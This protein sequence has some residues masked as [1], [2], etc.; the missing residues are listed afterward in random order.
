MQGQIL[1]HYRI[2]EK[3]GEGGM[4]EVFAAEDTTLGRRVA[5]KV[6]PAAMAA[7]EDRLRRFQREA[8]A[9]AA[10]NHPNIVTLYSVEEAD[11]Q[12][13]I[14]MELVEGRTLDRIIPAVGFD[15]GR[16]LAIA[17]PLTEALCAAHEKGITHRDLKPA[18]VMLGE[19][20][21]VKVLDFGLA[22][23]HAA[24]QGGG[25]ADLATLTQQGMLVGTV[26]YMAPEQVQGRLSDARA[27]LFSLGVIFYE[28]LTG[29]RPFRG[30][31]AAEVISAI[32]RDTPPPVTDLKADLP[33][34]L[35]KIVRRCLEKEPQR[36]YQ[37]VRDLLNELAEIAEEAGRDTGPSTAVLPFADLSPDGDQAYFCEGIAEELINALV[38][39]D[40]LRVASRLASFQ[41]QKVPLPEIG[42][43]LNVKTVL[44]G[45]VRKAG[46]RI[47]VTAQLVDVGGGH[48]LWSDRYDRKLED[49]F[50][51]QDEIA[52]SIV[53]AL[54]VT[55][56]SGAKPQPEKK[57]STTDV[58]AYDYY[59]R[60]RKF[61]YQFRKEGF[62]FA[63][64]MFA[65]AI[66]LDPGYAR[67]YAGVADCCSF[68]YM[69]FEASEDNLHEADTASR[70]A[71]EID[72]ASA[73]AHAARGLAM[74]LS[75]R[76]DE[77]RREFEEAIR[78]DP[79]L[80][81]AY[82]LF[83][84]ALF[85]QGELEEA[86]AMFAKA[87]EINPEDYQ[88]PFFEAQA[89]AGAGKPE[90]AE[91]AYRHALETVERHLELHPD[92]A[93]AVYLGA[94]GWIHLGDRDKG[95]EWAQRAVAID[96]H[97]PATL[98][99]VAC[100]YAQLGQVEHAI[101]C[102]EESVV[103]GMSEIGWLEHDPDLDPLREEPRFRELSERV[104]RQRDSGAGG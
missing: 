83:A 45:S 92:D 68:L 21:R 34:G 30:E 75:K 20:E 59:L 35:A 48:H 61:F 70:K 13:F 11:G 88:A 90:A 7:D 43:R 26:P 28:L 17:R 76:F 38:K 54:Q 23:L 64:Q 50:A 16:F 89:H 101:D 37:T 19:G 51:I 9:V 91:R 29:R 3:L 97:N 47:R 99:N 95:L 2:L 84:R 56:G 78:L 4:G 49:I 67:A 1:S 10:L 94:S 57:A 40:G 42:R 31:T 53:D 74:S 62:D 69:Y 81:E 12:R 102:L 72:P 55:L 65:R 63:R 73:E 18:N 93:R 32:L 77:A 8:Q 22:K 58:Q 52:A 44:S 15:L 96:P 46:D 82:Y 87:A 66:V 104:R 24:V 6:L 41:L 80:F 98:Y 86:A 25:E 36:R 103:N 100:T 27:D 14:T 60:G 33:D 71:V 85:A 39:I 5:I 79:K